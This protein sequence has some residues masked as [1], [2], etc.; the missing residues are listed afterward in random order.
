MINILAAIDFSEIS[1]TV[2]DQAAAIAKSFSSKLWLIHVAAPEPDF[3]GYG[4]GP[5]TERDWRAQTLREEHRY[6][7]DKALELEKAGIKVTPL[8]VQGATVET[9]LNEA[10]KLKAEMIVIGSHSRSALY[11][12]LVG[13]VSE[14]IVRQAS[15][16]VLIVPTRIKN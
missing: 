9:I 1:S 11:K 6:L 4:T 3:V 16:P 14:G 2:I 12:T 7:Q 5:Q 10:A 8:L 13:S 15:C